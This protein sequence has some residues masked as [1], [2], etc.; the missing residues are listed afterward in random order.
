M[1]VECVE[2]EI[3]QCGEEPEA[4]RIDAMNESPA[5]S[6]DRAIAGAH[7]IEIGVDLESNAAAVAGAS[8]GLLHLFIRFPDNGFHLRHRGR[9]PLQAFC[10]SKVGGG[11]RRL[12]K[13]LR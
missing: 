12:Y 9:S 3:I 2:R 13:T 1:G 5:P 11:L 10:A 7:V 6:A 8:I 4:L